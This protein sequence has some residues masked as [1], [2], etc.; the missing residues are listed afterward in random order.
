MKSKLKA[1]LESVLALLLVLSPTPGPELPPESGG[2]L[3]EHRLLEG[4]TCFSNKL[5]SLEGLNTFFVDRT[6]LSFFG[7]RTVL[8]FFDLSGCELVLFVRNT[9]NSSI[10]LLTSI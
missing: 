3:G 8:S 2:L 10:L 6:V 9:C 5:F 4:G 1:Y 7:D